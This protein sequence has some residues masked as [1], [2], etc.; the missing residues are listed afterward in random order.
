[1]IREVE[2]AITYRDDGGAVAGSQCVHRQPSD[3]VGRTDFGKQ[4]LAV[5]YVRVNVHHVREVGLHRDSEGDMSSD[6]HR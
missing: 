1:M 2:I 5:R 6:G 3:A 4:Q